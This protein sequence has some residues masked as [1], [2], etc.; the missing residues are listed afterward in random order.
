MNN[1]RLLFYVYNTTFFSYLD[2][3]TGKGVEGLGSGYAAGTEIGADIAHDVGE[4]GGRV[5]AAGQRQRP[6]VELHQP[7]SDQ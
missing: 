2:K 6:R 3:G 1:T 5:A 7:L 4:D